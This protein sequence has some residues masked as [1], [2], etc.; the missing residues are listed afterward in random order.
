MG[1]NRMLGMLAI[2]TTA[3]SAQAQ[4]SYNLTALGSLNGNGSLSY[5]MNESGIVVGQSTNAS[6]RPHFN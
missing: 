3:A 5:G 4:T 2:I 6:G 1:L